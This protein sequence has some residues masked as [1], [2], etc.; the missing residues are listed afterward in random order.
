MPKR[1][2]IKSV[3][4]I[5]AGPIIIGQACEFDYS[6]VQACKA[7]RE[8]G[9]KVI[10][11]NSNPATIMTD[12]ATADVTYIE[13]ITWQT[14][15][16]I[17]A[18]ERPD[19]ILP[20]MGGQTALNCALDLWHHGVLDKYKVELIGATP[21]AIDKAEDRLKFKDAMTKI[22]LG[23]A[24][25]GIAHSM[26]EAWAV[27]KEMGFPT[28]IR[29]S[30]TLGGTG[31]GIAYNPEEFE[32]ICKR[33]L[34]AS[35]TNELLIEE[36]LLGWKEYEME[37]VRDKADNCIIIC[38]IENLDPMGVHTGDS[39]TV[40]PAQTLTD[41]EYQVMRNASLAVLREIGV[42]TGGSNVQFSIN[43]K[44]GRMVVIEMNPRVSRSSALASK[45]TG[46]PIAKVAAKLAVGYTLDELR[47]DITG[48]A[49]P[50]SFE[51]SIDYVV[52]KIPR[53]AFEK[54]PTADSRLTTQMKSVGEVMA[55]GRT[56]QESFQKALRGLE[57]GVDGM[58]E[59][60]QDREVL[61]RELGEPGPERIWY[62]GDAFAMGL[63]VDEVF[64]LTKID[65]WF[66]VQIEQIVKIEL[67]IDQLA[68]EKGEGALAALDATTLRT[69]KQKGFSDRRLAKLLKTTEKAVRD[70]RRA[71][72]VRPVYK[73]VDTCAAEFATDTA[74]LYSTYEDECEAE[75]TDKKKIMVLGGG[76]NRIGQGI[77]FDYCCVHAALAM[78]E[79]GYETIMVNCN[80]ETVSTDYDTSDRLYFEPVT[81]ED[82]L[83]IVDKEKPVGVIV[84]YG[85]QTPLKLA[86][87]LEAEGVPI[88]GTSPD[89]I[90]AAEDRE[91][92][93]KLLH[94]LN[95]KQPPNATARTE[96]DALEKAAALG[97]PLV[98]RPS[99]VL[100]GRAM[101]IVH[102]Q[103][104]LERYMRE[105]VKVSNDSP[106]LLDRFLSNAIECDVDCVRDSAGVTFIGGVMEHIEQAGVHSGDSACSLPPYYLSKATV[107][108]IKRQTAAM[109]EGLSVVG[110]MNVQFAIQE[111]DGQD[112]IYVLEVNPR[113]SRTVPF[114][115]KATGIQLAKVAARC[116]AGQTLASQG[117]TKEVTPPYFSVKEAVFPFVKFPGVDTI[118]GPEM[119]STGEVMGVGKTFGEAFVK[120]QLG[121]GTKLPTS[122]KVFLTVKNADKAR[123]VDIARQLVA[124][125][126]EL[127]A[128]KGTAAA[129][130]AA[131]VPVK[132]VNKV[133]EG[134]PHIVDM[135]KNNE[136]VMVI[137]TVEE[138]RNAI[139]DSRAI[140]TSSLLA[141]VT[142]F[143]TIFGAEAAVEGMQHMEQ[144]DVISVQE[145]H[146]Q[147]VA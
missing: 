50:A 85:G 128:T 122:G 147:L 91:R 35:P 13:P 47:N 116:M 74:Y 51:P 130:E 9:Y 71:L 86:L 18:K 80:P 5:G 73:R 137:N 72:N 36:S 129:I 39:I 6:G 61:E 22:G 95:L 15:E 32:T 54:F 7:L 114:V 25:S 140:R 49:T 17:I 24:R 56:F 136:I 131:G 139:A 3:L 30:F 112:V 45:A 105:A 90:D 145:M 66:L 113:A 125:G 20:T 135:I 19:A 43:P 126:F 97:Y 27:Q 12:P 8:E 98:V 75:P 117:I 109:A 84:Q 119:K 111:V 107:D 82:V 33:G 29:P 93:Q 58:N 143:T 81:L 44:D 123:A 103:R 110:L 70:Q 26:D 67:D 64:E 79:D 37:V 46:F 69:L 138:R 100:G 127:V 146:A 4:I 41:K 87:G 83:E 88:I 31:G 53:F 11:I 34:E 99:Y 68:A 77:E 108:E 102:E 16:K 59:K 144:L 104:D 40:A 14:V 124:L 23:S 10:L 89:M 65:R 115:S 141:R 21:E 48:G 142:T 62:V 2:D 57:V 132:V 101:E 1:T 78:R 96:A 94:D 55:M 63:S 38:S 118:L 106:V 120:S 52:T 28:V 92:F 134:R 133:T 121:A 76:P 42:D 60:T